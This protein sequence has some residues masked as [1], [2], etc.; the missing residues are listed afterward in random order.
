[1]P[2]MTLDGLNLNQFVDSTAKRKKAERKKRHFSYTNRI[3]KPWDGRHIN[4][5]I[6]TYHD[7]APL[8]PVFCFDN[9]IHAKEARMRI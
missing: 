2:C 6:G 1:M 4:I 9:D 5:S 7:M 3:W 8:N